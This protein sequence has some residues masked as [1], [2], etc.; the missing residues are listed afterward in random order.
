MS[1]IVRFVKWIGKNPK[2]SIFFGGVLSYGFNWMHQKYQIANVMR[3]YC[4]EAKKYGEMKAP[5][6]AK[7]KKVLII[8]NPAANKRNAEDDFNEF[9]APILNMAGYFIDIVKTESDLHAIRLLGEEINEQYDAFIIAGGDGTISESLTGLLR[10]NDE[11]SANCIIGVIPLGLNNQFSYMFLNS[12]TNVRNK[13]EA[14]KAK[15]E[16]ALAIVKGKTQK[17]DVIKIELVSDDEEVAKKVF[18]GVGSVFWGSFHDILRKKDKYWLT[19]SLRN[20]TACLFNGVFPRD[21]VNWNCEAKMIYSAP[22]S[23]CSNCY[24]KPESKSQK[25][26]NSRWWSK[27][28]SS[29]EVVPEY[30]KVLNPHCLE[31]TE[32]DINTSEFAI[33]TNCQEGIVNETPKLTIKIGD[34]PNN[35]GP[36]YIWESWKRVYNKKFLDLPN[37]TN[38]QSRQV[39]LIPK[40]DNSEEK[41][42]NF[43]SI[44]HN[45]FEVRPI[46][47]TLL[48][49]KVDFFV[50]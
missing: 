32:I 27:F 45:L 2:K 31:T 44:D 11:I 30:S 50:S 39:L 29:K 13:V 7:L 49:K 10:R 42:E 24:E 18:Y 1:R 6:N 26:H 14:V 17:Q 48:P 9:V 34:K 37:S 33:T 3:D 4:T 36:S 23:G 25:L 35:Y 28:N 15:A 19:G 40:E 12:D 5:I 47:V 22:C 46:K 38:L 20:Y 8:L 21:G 43:F 41:K 16:A